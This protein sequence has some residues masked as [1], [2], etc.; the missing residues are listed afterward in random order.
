MSR[1]AVSADSEDILS[2]LRRLL[3]ERPASYKSAAP[4]AETTVSAGESPEA[5]DGLPPVECLV[6]TEALRIHPPEAESDDAVEGEPATRRLHLGAPLAVAAGGG[7]NTSDDQDGDNEKG[8]A[9]TEEDTA[10]AEQTEPLTDD[11][12]ETD[13]TVA[14]DFG[15]Q[16]EGNDTSADTTEEAEQ[17][18][19]QAWAKARELDD[20]EPEDILRAEAAEERILDEGALRE[21]VAQAVREE[22][23]GELGERITRNVKKLVRREIQ[24]ALA[25]RAFD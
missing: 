24:R 21:I 1:P 12:A 14:E 5:R 20:R 9:G 18:T 10:S 8:A 15:K 7:G 16:A 2:S 17:M 19:Q 4:V 11:M 22:L 3:A 6:L 25:E 13:Q 23:M